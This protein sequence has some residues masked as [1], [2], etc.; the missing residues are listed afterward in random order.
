MIHRAAH[1][2]TCPLAAG[3]ESM[4]DPILPRR[5]DEHRCTAPIEPSVITRDGGH[6]GLPRMQR[7]D[8]THHAETLV[9]VPGIDAFARSCDGSAGA[10]QGKAE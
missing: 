7:T 1:L 6:L 9:R 10:A 3:D 2:R 4:A 5:N 8:N